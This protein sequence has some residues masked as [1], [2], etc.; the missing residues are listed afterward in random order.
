MTPTT[1]GVITNP[2]T[3]V[4]SSMMAE[5]LHIEPIDSDDKLFKEVVQQATSRKK[6]S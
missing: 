5:E 3:A 6:Y 2:G 1:R 4:N